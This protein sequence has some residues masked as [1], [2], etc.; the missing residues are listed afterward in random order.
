MAVV[1]TKRRV[2]LLTGDKA[3]RCKVHETSRLPRQTLRPLNVLRA[4]GFLAPGVVRG[5]NSGRVASLL[6][7][8]RH[9]D[10]SIRRNV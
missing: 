7:V 3:V 2:M 10:G 4:L 5:L 9:S 8:E 1:K 6:G